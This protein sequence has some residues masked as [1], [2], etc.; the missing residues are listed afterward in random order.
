MHGIAKCAAAWRTARRSVDKLPKLSA[1]DNLELRYKH[2]LPALGT[3]YTGS[4][5]GALKLAFGQGQYLYDI[6]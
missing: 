1:E 5:R 3:H 4:N 6:Q 2:L